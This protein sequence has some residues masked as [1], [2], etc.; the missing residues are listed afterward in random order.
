MDL[1]GDI[2]SIEVGEFRCHSQLIT[3]RRSLKTLSD[4][5]TWGLTDR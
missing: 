3:V 1:K 4:R 2:L 5:Q